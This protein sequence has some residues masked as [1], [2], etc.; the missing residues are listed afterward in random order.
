M[1]TTM[2][3]AGS[4]LIS[5]IALVALAISPALAEEVVDPLARAEAADAQAEAAQ[6]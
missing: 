2:F 4:S 5:V 1:K 6:A 3:G